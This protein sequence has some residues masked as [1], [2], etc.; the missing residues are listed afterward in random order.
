MNEVTFHALPLDHPARRLLDTLSRSS[1][2]IDDEATFL[3]A[4]FEI[5]RKQRRSLM[6]VAT[7]PM[8]AG[9]IFKVFFVDE[10]AHDREKPRGWK[11]FARRCAQAERI[12]RVIQEHGLRHFRVPRKWLFHAPHHPSCDPGDQPVILVAEFQDLLPKPDNEHAWCHSIT[13]SHLDELYAI[14]DGAGGVS[15]RPDNIALAKQ[16]WFAFI[17]TEY[18]SRRHDY[19]GIVPYLSCEMRQYWLSL[20]QRA[21]PQN[22]EDSSCA[23]LPGQDPARHGAG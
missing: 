11:G 18:S 4:G 12:R 19:E 7:H 8:A 23:A 15:S 21:A 10:Q 14:I 2:V 16:G 17:D 20:I 9:Y 22:D 5:H 1:G 13:R 3:A 6:R